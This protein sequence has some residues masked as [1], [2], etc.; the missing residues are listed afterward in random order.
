[1]INS[2]F[3]EPSSVNE[4]TKAIRTTMKRACEGVK[5]MAIH[6]GPSAGEV[7]IIMILVGNTINNEGQATVLS[8]NI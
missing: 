4:K 6:V 5:L 1:L 7:M 2:P 8:N 3:Q